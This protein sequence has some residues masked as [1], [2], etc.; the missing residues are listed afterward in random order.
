MDVKLKIISHI[1]V[2][3]SN[4]ATQSN[5]IKEITNTLNIVTLNQ[6]KIIN[7]IQAIEAKLNKPW[8]KKF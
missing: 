7:S 6:E 4:L 3:E 2:L 1:K 8:Y 5:E